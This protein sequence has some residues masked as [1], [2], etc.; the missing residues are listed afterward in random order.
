[1]NKPRN[2]PT[3]RPIYLFVT[4]L[5]NPH[6]YQTA[7]DL[8]APIYFG[9]GP[10]NTPL[11][12]FSTCPPSWACPQDPLLA[13]LR[14]G[15]SQSKPPHL[16]RLSS[17]PTQ[18]SACLSRTAGNKT[19]PD[20]CPLKRF[21]NLKFRY[22]GAMVQTIWHSHVS[23]WFRF[24]WSPVH[25]YIETRGH[26][27]RCHIL[28]LSSLLVFVYETYLSSKT[29]LLLWVVPAQALTQLAFPRFPQTKLPFSIW[30][31]FDQLKNCICGKF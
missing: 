13:C 17:G 29:P 6:V 7:A 28:S 1:M 24:V 5:Y 2:L 20:L 21:N 14:R 8:Y 31:R 19:Y 9:L 12:P 27:Q 16:S 15:N 23:R 18:L 22:T 26:Q 3:T 4:I 25:M 10:I 30:D 11:P